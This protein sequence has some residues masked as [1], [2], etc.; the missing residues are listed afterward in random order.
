MRRILAIALLMVFM[1]MA[2]AQNISVSSF[3]L[4][5]TDLTANTAG[6][7][8]KDQNGETAALIKVVTTQ[9]GFTFDG[10][11]LG[12]VKTVPKPSEIWVY[13]PKGLKKITISHP[14]L[15][16]LR[17]YYLN[18]PIKAAR[19][20]EMKL[21]TGE[22]Q[23]IINESARSQYLIIKVNPSNAIV[24]LNNEVLPTSEGVAQ[25]FIKLGTYDYRAQAKNYH[26]SAGK[27]TIDNPNEK[28]ILTINLEPAF[29]WINIPKTDELNGAQVYVDNTLIGVAPI[30]S[31]EIPSGNHSVKIV[32]PLYHTYERNVLIKDGETEILNPSLVPNFST[33]EISVDNDAGIYVNDEFVGTSLWK[34]KLA[35]GTYALQARKKNHRTT[36]KNI[37][38][39]SDQEKVSIKL[40]KPSPIT[41]DI[42]ITS[43]PSFSDVEIDGENLGKT[44]LYLPSILIG[45]HDI[46]IKHSGYVLYTSSLTIEEN[47]N[48]TINAVLSKKV[49]IEINCNVPSADFFIDGVACGTASGQ[50]EISIGKHDIEIRP[51]DIGFFE[52]LRENLN[53]KGNEKTLDFTL[54]QKKV[55]K[56][57]KEKKAKDDGWEHVY[58]TREPNNI[59]GKTF[60]GNVKGTSG[61][62]GVAYNLGIKNAT[63]SM[64][65][66]AAKMGGAMILITSEK[67]SFGI[68]LEGKVYK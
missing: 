62:S 54:Q 7:I 42:N 24:E 58:V 61:W 2:E 6:T 47:K 45:Q 67:S 23:T 22:I 50:K 33:V 27:V 4:L 1:L 43:E 63:N 19:T 51:L 16:M 13:V 31:Q 39:S 18:I 17:D 41:G 49:L 14:Q 28:T 40:E 37:D 46:S 11:A 15:G 5:E 57:N 52:T 44:P 32:K 35:T 48:T 29:G 64:K 20:Y 59:N 56:A 65:K 34:G 9:T 55:K 66:K 8:E 21:V 38:I 10:G 3:R 53:V 60:L 12:I 25:K 26:T 68:T 36:T 30:K